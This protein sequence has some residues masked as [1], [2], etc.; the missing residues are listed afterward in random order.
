MLFTLWEL[1]DLVIMVFAIGYIFSSFIKREPAAGYD[2]LTYYKKNTLFQ[3]IKYASIIAA[4]AVI[5]HE[6]GHKF[7]AMFFGATATLHAPLTWYAI[8]IVMKLLNFPLFFFVGGYVEHTALPPLESAL[9]SASGPF[10]NLLL[11]LICTGL[12]KYRLVNKK[13]YM[14]YIPFILIYFICAIN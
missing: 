1:I 9:V 12:I 7:V 10:V 8:V 14:I 11:F 6:L 2:P 4:P 3:D 5:L 13:Y